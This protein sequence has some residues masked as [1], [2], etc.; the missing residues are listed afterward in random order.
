MLVHDHP[1]A[2]SPNVTAGILLCARAFGEQ[3]QLPFPSGAQILSATGATK[4]RAYEVAAEVRELLAALTRPPGRPRASAPSDFSSKLA[5]LRGQVLRFVMS[6]PGSVHLGA[7]RS[8]YGS[9]FRLFALELCERHPDV[10]VSELAE[11]LLVP[12]GT[13]EDWLR[14][15]RPDVPH[16]HEGNCTDGVPADAKLAQIETVLSAWQSWHGD[17]GSFCEHVRRDH[18]LELGRTTIASILFAH[19]ERTPTRRGRRS[20]DEHALRG[21]FETFFPGAQWVADGKRLE[22]LVDGEVF[23]LNLELVVDAA[24][25]AAVGIAVTDEEDG[26]AV[27]D[28][29]ASGVET[30]GAPP[31]AMLLDNRPSNHTPDV[32]A[33]LGDTIRIRA[34]EARPQ[35]KAHV[36]GAFGLFSQKTPPIEIDTRDPHKLAHAVATIV[37][38]T[39][40]RAIN[41]APRR[42][43]GGNTRVDLYAQSVTAEE[44]EAALATLRERMRKQQRAR[45]TRTARL[46]PVVRALLDGAFARLELSDPERHVRDAI[47]C[48][49]V[50]VIVDAIAIFA[51]KREHGSLPH[52][53]DARYLFGI[54]KNLHHVHEADLITDALLRERLAASDRFLES[55][56]AERDAILASTTDST[57]SLNAVVDRLVRATR[58]IDRHFWVEAAASII[59]AVRDN[60]PL[61]RRAC[62]R[63]H[64]AF[65]LDPRERHRLVRMLVRRLSPLD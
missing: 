64:A 5:E 6:H 25:D 9:S 38:L 30:T 21:A 3:L 35:N 7:E 29:F 48:Y 41:R 33:A 63:I 60:D 61:C 23:G 19:G 45:A 56:V 28:A 11:A 12:R 2:V 27:R 54:V 4:S 10:P 65:S 44:R 46:D 43:R 26:A 55:L 53:V 47:A 16:R 17:F 1:P 13:L 39:F 40:F 14:A 15:P 20:R 8:W 51:A 24:T 58:T 36:E 22:V 50:N 57:A 49:P 34:T 62:R 42:D 59:L 18:R 31:I 32:D 37:V 52:G